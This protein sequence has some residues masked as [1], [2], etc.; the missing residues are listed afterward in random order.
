[1]QFTDR[2]KWVFR[3]NAARRWTWSRNSPDGEPLIGSS[4][5]FASREECVDD[6]G[7]CGYTPDDGTT[8][9]RD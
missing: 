4:R 9:E 7:R 2:D 8:P 6:A 3:V 1:M 5:S